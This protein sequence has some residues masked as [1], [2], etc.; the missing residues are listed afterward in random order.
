VCPSDGDVVERVEAARERR[1]RAPG[2]ALIRRDSD[3]P[4]VGNRDVPRDDDAVASTGRE[5]DVPETVSIL[6]SDGASQDTMGRQDRDPDGS[7]GV[8]FVD[9]GHDGCTPWRDDDMW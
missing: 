2:T 9:P 5:H 1:D 3:T 6:E 8:S 4:L 7:A